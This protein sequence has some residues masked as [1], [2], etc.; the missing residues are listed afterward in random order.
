M[1]ELRHAFRRL[2]RSPGFA[3]LTVITLAVGIGASTA[4]FSTLRPVLLDSVPYPAADRLVVVADRNG[5]TGTP[6]DVTFGTY[7]ELVERSRTIARVTVSRSWQPTLTGQGD[8]ERLQGRVSARPT[9]VS[10][11]LPRFLDATSARR[12]TRQGHHPSASYRTG[13]GGEGSARTR[14]SWDTPSGSTGRW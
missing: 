14:R 7:R 10:S 4:I 12:T 6:F 8:A 5:T 9:S 3:L 2:R 11:V 13:C 1:L